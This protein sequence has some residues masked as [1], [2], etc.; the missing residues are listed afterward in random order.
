[1][2]LMEIQIWV[3]KHFPG[4]L[5]SPEND[6]HDPAMPNRLYIRL[7]AINETRRL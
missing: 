4:I 7:E 2:F 6:S 1:M 3:K 5:E